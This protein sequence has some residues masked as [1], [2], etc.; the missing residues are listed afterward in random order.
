MMYGTTERNTKQKIKQTIYTEIFWWQ[1]LF[2]AILLWAV[3]ALVAAF[4]TLSALTINHVYANESGTV[5]KASSLKH[6]AQ[7]PEVSNKISKTATKF[8]KLHPCET[9]ILHSLQPHY[10]VARP[11]L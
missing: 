11:D 5:R 1:H 3:T 10:R 8:Q 9:I 4:A 2:T 7:K 6:L